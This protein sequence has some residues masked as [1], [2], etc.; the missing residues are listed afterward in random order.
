MNFKKVSSAICTS[1][2]LNG[3][4]VDLSMDIVNSNVIRA[5]HLSSMQSLALV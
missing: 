4:I 3:H 1:M 2:L 5:W